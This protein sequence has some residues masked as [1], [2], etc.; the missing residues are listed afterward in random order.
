MS[1]DYVDLPG[2]CLPNADREGMH[3]HA[4]LNTVAFK[5]RIL[6]KQNALFH[7]PRQVAVLPKSSVSGFSFAIRKCYIG[8]PLLPNLW[9]LPLRSEVQNTGQDKDR[10]ASE[11]VWRKT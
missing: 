4:S 10:T 7:S 5:A 8:T 2:I 9:S 6:L 1:W 3:H 11:C